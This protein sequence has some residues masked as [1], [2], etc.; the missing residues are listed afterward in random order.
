MTNKQ[1]LQTE[2][3]KH[4][5]QLGCY[6]NQAEKLGKRALN[7]IVEAWLMN[8]ATEII[9]SIKGVKYVVMLDTVDHEKDINMITLNTY[10][11][12]FGSC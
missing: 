2:L 4:G 3:S 11:E 10:R 9:T 1:Y 7:R 12:T 8:E 5:W 6:T